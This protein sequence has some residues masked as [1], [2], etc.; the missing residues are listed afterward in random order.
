MACREQVKSDG[1]HAP[2]IVGKLRLVSGVLESEAREL[3]GLSRPCIAASKVHTQPKAVGVVQSFP[4]GAKNLDRKQFLV[5]A[6]DDLH[7]FFAIVRREGIDETALGEFRLGFVVQV[8]RF[9]VGSSFF[10]AD[11]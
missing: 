1:S 3:R 4:I 2:L 8:K 7:A 10:D 6:W 5:L 9:G 11:G